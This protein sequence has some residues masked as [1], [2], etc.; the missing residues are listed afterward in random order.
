MDRENLF[1]KC[2]ICANNID[3]SKI[4]QSVTVKFYEDMKVIRLVADSNISG[5]C[6]VAFEELKKLWGHMNEMSKDPLSIGVEIVRANVDEFLSQASCLI[7]YPCMHR[8]Q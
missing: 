4:K 1:C 3:E 5:S 6:K 8:K 7:A 2:F